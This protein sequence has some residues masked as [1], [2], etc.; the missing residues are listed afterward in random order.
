[1]PCGSIVDIETVSDADFSE[2]FQWQVGDDLFDFTGCNL[3]MMVRHHPEDAEVLIALDS[4]PTHFGGI[5]FND[6]DPENDNKVTSFNIFILREQMVNMPPG[7]YVQ[8]L[9]L[10]RPDGLRDDIWHG[11]LTHSIGP[12]R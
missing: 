9:L 10:L 5:M 2:A 8:S 4:D 6:P 12:T 11:T 7:S 3:L 1:M